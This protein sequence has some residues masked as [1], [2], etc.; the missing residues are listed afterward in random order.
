MGW[1]WMWCLNRVDENGMVWYGMVGVK[2]RAV[3]HPCS[4]QAE[5]ELVVAS[6]SRARGC[7]VAYVGGSMV[8]TEP[9]L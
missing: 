1:L 2:L 3:A 9:A 7:A 4:V 5:D 6:S 8:A